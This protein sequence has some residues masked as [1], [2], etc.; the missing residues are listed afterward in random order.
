MSKFAKFTEKMLE[1]EVIQKLIGKGWEF[2]KADELE[3]ESYDEP[4]LIKNLI[5]KIIE[6]NKDIELDSE[7]VK[8]VLNCLKLAG[9]KEEGGRKIL[10]Y[11]K[12]GVPV[13]LKK[14]KTVKYIRLFDYACVE[15]NEFILTRQAVY[16]GREDIRTDVVLY[17]NGVPLVNIELKNPASF[18]ESGYDAYRQIKDYEKIVPELYKYVQIGIAAEQ[19]AKYFPV[20]PWQDEAKISEWREEEIEDPIDAIIELLSKHKQD[21]ALTKLNE[22]N[23]G[24][25]M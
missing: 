20:V 13:K 15:K 17:V 4:L 18:A 10:Q 14:E 19:T 1:D 6:V 9:T 22:I 8:T 2:V 23:G 21:E 3:R 11:L 25:Y 7:D 16:H 12:F 24:T 5:R